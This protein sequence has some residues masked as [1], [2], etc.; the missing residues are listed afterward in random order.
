MGVVENIGAD[1]WPKQGHYLGQRC[2]VVFRYDTSR[3]SLGTIV[4]DDAEAP[5]QTI[6]RL[7]DGRTVLATECQ[8]QPA[9]LSIG[10][11]AGGGP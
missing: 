6:I 8:Y 1:Q 10:T 2:K 7:D 3:P 11:P 4:R 5:W 9:K